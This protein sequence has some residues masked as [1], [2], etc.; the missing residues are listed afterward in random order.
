MSKFTER[1][2]EIFERQQKT[3]AQALAELTSLYDKASRSLTNAVVAEQARGTDDALRRATRFQ[4]L[5]D[6]VEQEIA[7]LQKKSARIITDSGKRSYIDTYN[8]LAYA[9]DEM[10]NTTKYRIAG[11]TVYN[12]FPFLDSKAVQEAL[13]NTSVAGKTMSP[14]QFSKIMAN[15]RNT[16]RE[17]VRAI[18]ANVIATGFGLDAG[19]Q[20]LEP[21]FVALGDSL[22][23]ASNRAKTTAR[24]E[25]LRAYS[26]AQ[27]DADREAVESGVEL[28]YKWDTSKDERVRSSHRQM[29]GQIA[30]TNAQGE[31]FFQYPD[32]TR[33][34]APRVYG[35]ASNVI[36]CRCTRLSYPAG[37]EPTARCYRQDGAWKTDATNLEYKT[38]LTE[39]RKRVK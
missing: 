1:Q 37:F 11:E 26:Y 34:P 30:Q 24:T 25:V 31:P 21:L 29:Q 32:G 8:R 15:Q 27:M 2:L 16:L 35:S 6:E 12:N 22:S 36:N 9:Y 39:W 13:F 4:K 20:A 10:V 38:W 7:D 17:G 18:I 23:K 19:S 3:E 5:L 33:T 28:E 14:V